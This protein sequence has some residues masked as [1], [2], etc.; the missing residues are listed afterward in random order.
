MNASIT[1]KIK[2]LG[3]VAGASYRR[4]DIKLLEKYE[5]LL[6]GNSTAQDYLKIKRGL[7]EETIK[8]F[9]LGYDSQY[10]AIAIPI[11][12]KDELINIKYRRIAPKEDEPKYTS[13]RGAETWIFN[14]QGINEGIN[15]RGVLVVEGEFDAMSVWQSGIHNVVSPASGK[16]SYGL[17]LEMLD[18]IPKVFICYDNDKPGKEAALKFSARVGSDKSYEVVYPNGFKDANEYLKAHSSEDFR[19][20]LKA[21]RPFYK[22]TFKSLVDIIEEARNDKEA[23]LML[24]VLPDVKMGKDWLVIVSGKSNVGKT[25]Y[26][27]NIAGELADKE[28]PCLILPFERGIQVVGTRYFQ[29]KYSMSEGEIETMDEQTWETIKNDCATAPVYF[30]MPSKQETM[31]VIKRSK[32]IFNTRVVIVDHLDLLVRSSGNNYERELAQ[33]IQELKL[34]AQECGVIIMAVHHVRKTDSP[35]AKKPRQ[36]GIEDLKGS[37]AVFQD[38]E[39]VVM[40]T[41]EA[42]GIISVNVLKSKGK[43]SIRKYNVNNETGKLSAFVPSSAPETSSGGVAASLQYFDDL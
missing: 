24:D 37:S 43:M 21:A 10:N 17:W 2:S 29:V 13:E 12:K 9:R 22:H 31:D 34:V 36:P 8:H 6:A 4:P 11:F 7:S 1:D 40:L 3:S 35:G 41:S 32:R 14:E 26:V 33:T 42:E 5:M 27:L 18:V 30:A 28:I 38:P 16:D 39:C 15:K 19:E 25:S 23:K 20:L